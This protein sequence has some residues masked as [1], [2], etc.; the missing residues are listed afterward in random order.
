MRDR[1]GDLIVGHG[2]SYVWGRALAMGDFGIRA[3]FETEG[4]GPAVDSAIGV[5]REG[6]EIPATV[7][8]FGEEGVEGGNSQRL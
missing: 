3:G 7:V 2:K 4:A 8:D 6:V 1:A 5:I